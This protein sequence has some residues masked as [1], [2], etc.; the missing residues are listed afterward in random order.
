[1]NFS[2]EPLTEDQCNKSR[3]FPLLEPG[4]YDFQVMDAHVKV[5]RAG[6]PMIELILKVWGKNGAEFTIYDYLLSTPNM[7]WKLKHFCDSVGLAKEYE[8]KSFDEFKCINRFGKADI[9]Y[10]PGAKKANGDGYYS[11]KNAVN[12]YV[13]AE[14]KVVKPELNDD[15]PF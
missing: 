3:Q 5:S 15:L 4:V 14:E 13:K 12:D 1:M 10:Q 2:Y 11:D 6:N 8:S 9:V 7:A